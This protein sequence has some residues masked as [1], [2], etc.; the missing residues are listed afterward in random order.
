MIVLLTGAPDIW[1][2][3]KL[4]CMLTKLASK[5]NQ[6]KNFCRRIHSFGFTASRDFTA[7]AAKA[8]LSVM[9]DYLSEG[10]FNHINYDSNLIKAYLNQS[11]MYHYK[12]TQA[13][14]YWNNV[15]A[16]IIALAWCKNLRQTVIADQVR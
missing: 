13:Y 7:A 12:S 2:T 14:L 11:V 6:G 10:E 4:D 8:V 16:K 3:R 1:G 5:I 15:C 9:R